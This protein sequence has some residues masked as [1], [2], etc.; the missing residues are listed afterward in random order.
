MSK[1]SNTTRSG[2]ASTTR[3]TTISNATSSGVIMNDEEMER[4]AAQER[5]QMLAKRAERDRLFANATTKFGKDAV[6]PKYE[7]YYPYE[8]ENRVWKTDPAV[9][10]KSIMPAVKNSKNELAKAEKAFEKASKNID[11]KVK[12]KEDRQSKKEWERRYKEEIKDLKSIV[13]SNESVARRY[14]KS[15]NRL[16]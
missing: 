1:G 13:R 3:A 15:I 2:G 10:I 7:G 4:V 6:I 9:D 14:Q 12:T 16:K 5:A 11:K 8:N